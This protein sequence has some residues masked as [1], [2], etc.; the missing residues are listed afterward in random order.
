MNDYK[1]NIVAGFHDHFFRLV[2]ALHDFLIRHPKEF[3][4]DIDY[5][6]TKDVHPDGTLEK[7]FT[8]KHN[9]ITYHAYVKDV[10]IMINSKPHYIKYFV[11]KVTLLHIIY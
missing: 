8:F 3:S 5:V 1:I 9:N 11:Y 6:I 7:H 10:M 4:S 2:N